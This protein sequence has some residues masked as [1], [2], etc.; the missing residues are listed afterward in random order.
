MRLL[1]AAFSR[2]S[3][4]AKYSPLPVYG[5]TGEKK[6]AKQTAL[7]ATGLILWWQDHDRRFVLYR[8]G[9]FDPTDV[10]RGNDWGFFEIGQGRSD[11]PFSGW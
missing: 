11:E 3:E 6:Y 8:N 7:Q 1:R 9:A 10:A 2:T 5:A 4:S